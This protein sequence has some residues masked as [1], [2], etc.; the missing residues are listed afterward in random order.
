MLFLLSVTM[1]AAAGQLFPSS[2]AIYLQTA[3]CTHKLV[4]LVSYRPLAGFVNSPIAPAQATPRAGGITS[5]CSHRSPIQPP[6]DHSRNQRAPRPR[7]RVYRV[8]AAC[9]QNRRHG[10]RPH[11]YKPVLGAHPTKIRG[12]GPRGHVEV[13]G[14]IENFLRKILKS[15]CRHSTNS[16]SNSYGDFEKGDRFTS[17]RRRFDAV[18]QSPCDSQKQ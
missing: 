11:E 13:L 15:F 17:L 14:E 8:K 2:D 10:R 18:V 5:R 3:A 6:R 12:H 4:L 7:G 16:F 9:G 1:N